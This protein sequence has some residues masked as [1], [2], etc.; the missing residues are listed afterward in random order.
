MQASL[1]P[2]Q[3]GNPELLIYPTNSTGQFCGQGGNDNIVIVI[4]IIMVMKVRTQRG[5]SSSSKTFL[6]ALPCPPWL[7][8]VQHHRSRMPF[9][10]IFHE[11]DTLKSFLNSESIV[12]QVCVEECPTQTTSLWAYAMAKTGGVPIDQ[13]P[14]FPDF[15]LKFQRKL[16]IPS[17][18]EEEWTSAVTDTSRDPLIKLINERKCPAYTIQSI[19]IAGRC[20]PDFGLIQGQTDNST[21]MNDANG[22]PIASDEGI[23]DVGDV[24]ESIKSI[25]DILNLQQTAEKIFSDLVKVRWML[26]AGVGI[27]KI[28]LSPLLHFFLRPQVLESPSSGSS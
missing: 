27:S 6:S 17:L 24:L 2:F 7:M 1:S 19:G 4:I 18:T 22:N 15:D 23:V 28:S 20:V 13:I 14:G 12:N 11:Q 10:R 9:I 8:A 25:V 21:S 16:C 3:D 5:R 26:L